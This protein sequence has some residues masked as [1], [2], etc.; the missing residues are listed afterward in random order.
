MM[1]HKITIS[2]D[3]NQWLKRL[4]TQ[5]NEQ[6]N[7]NPKSPKLLGQRIRK[8]YYKT[9]GNSAKN[10]PMST[11]F[12]KYTADFYTHKRKRNTQTK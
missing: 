9:L 1:I 12:L 5:N 2:V 7:Q 10:S 4:D 3:Y 6:T 8:R 11:P